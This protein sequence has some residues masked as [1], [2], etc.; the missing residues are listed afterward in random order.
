ER[1]IGAT[2]GSQRLK[3]PITATRRAVGALNTNC[4]TIGT[5]AL[6]VE[7][8]TGA[9]GVVVATRAGEPGGAVTVPRM[10]NPANAAAATRPPASAMRHQPPCGAGK[11]ARAAGGRRRAAAAADTTLATA[12]SATAGR[13]WSSSIARRTTGSAPSRKSRVFLTTY[14][15]ARAARARN[16]SRL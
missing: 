11:H 4:S 9:I 10:M 15:L 3:S 7:Y 5:T 12:S 1:A 8:A 2:D 6:S 13:R 16:R 14:H